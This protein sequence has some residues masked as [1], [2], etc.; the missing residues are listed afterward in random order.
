MDWITGMQ[1]AIDYIEANLTEEIDYE[2]VAAE[3][4]FRATIFKGCSV[5]FADIRLE[6]ILGYDVYPWQVQNWQ[7]AKKK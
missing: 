7:M 4:F 1:K 6:N 3:S 2:K 5:F